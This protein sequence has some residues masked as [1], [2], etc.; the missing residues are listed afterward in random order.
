MVALGSLVLLAISAWM[1]Y[2]ESRIGWIFGGVGIVGWA[3]FVG[4]VVADVRRAR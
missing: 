3:I 1:L 4:A 2:N